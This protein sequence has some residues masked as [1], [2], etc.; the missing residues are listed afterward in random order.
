M[1]QV[2]ESERIRFVR[3]TEKLLCDYLEMVN[4]IEHVARFI[5]Q[6]TEPY[7]LEEERAFIQSKLAENAAIYSMIAKNSGDFIGNIEFMDVADGTA[8][9]GIA[10]TAKK[11][12]MGFGVEAISRL[13]AHGF[14]TLGLNRVFL[15]VYPNNTRAIHAYEK[16]GFRRYN[17]TE[18]DVFMELYRD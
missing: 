14:S 6:R 11:Q 9:L 17:S 15:K 18:E 1:E 12:N 7:T 3:V 5:G 16:C 10:I 13:L 2:F 8:E 4:D